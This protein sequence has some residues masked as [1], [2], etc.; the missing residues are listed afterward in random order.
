MTT[1]QKITPFIWY[2]GV[3]EEAANLYTSLFPDSK[4][5]SVMPGPGGKAMV[6]DFEIAGQRYQ[7]F[8]GG[9]GQTFSEAVSFVVH[10]DSQEEV[11]HYWNGLTANGGQEVECGWLRDR[12]GVRW[13]IV[14]VRFFELMRDPDP[15]RRAAVFGAM[16]KMK[17]FDIAALEAA[18]ASA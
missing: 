7:A 13:Q 5:A 6:V 18:H 4:I 1:K 12:F 3:A 15:K 17:K 11:D 10:C 8:N 9:P 16:M 2:D 14:P